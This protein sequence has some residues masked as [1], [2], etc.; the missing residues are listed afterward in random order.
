MK[1]IAPETLQSGAL[2]E[3]LLETIVSAHYLVLQMRMLAGAAG[4]QGSAETGLMAEALSR[5]AHLAGAKWIEGAVSGE[6]EDEPGR[7]ENR[8]RA[9]RR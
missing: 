2:D 8:P 6:A 9:V 3:V 4:F 1:D 7:R 5:W